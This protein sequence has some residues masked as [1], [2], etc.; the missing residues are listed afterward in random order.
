MLTYAL[1]STWYL[2]SSRWEHVK[3]KMHPWQQSPQTYTHISTRSHLLCVQAGAHHRL[4]LKAGL[5]LLRGRAVD[6]RRQVDD[7]HL[8]RCHLHHRYHQHQKLQEHHLHCDSLFLLFWQ[9]KYYQHG[10]QR[11]TVE[12]T[13]MPKQTVRQRQIIRSPQ[14]IPSTSWP[15][16]GSDGDDDDGHGGYIEGQ[17]HQGY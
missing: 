10:R 11:S 6:D 9:W 8:G 15:I 4:L 3:R 17:E 16:A 2:V 1:V 7:P 14:P 5:Q 13:A 12:K